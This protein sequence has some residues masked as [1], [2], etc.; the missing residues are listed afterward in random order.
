MNSEVQRE[1]ARLDLLA[2]WL[3]SRFHIP[4]TPLRFGLD[5]LIGLIPVAGDTLMGLPSVWLIWRAHRLGLPKRKL[6]RMGLN[7]G[8]DYV[9]GSIPILGDIFDLGFKANLKNAAILRAYFGC[10]AFD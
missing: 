7:T 9:L 6:A 10:P 8:L 5:T 3:D 4:G 1:L 2:R